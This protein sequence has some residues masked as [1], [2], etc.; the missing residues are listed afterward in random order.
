[1][2]TRNLI[3]IL[4]A[5]VFALACHSITTKQRYS[6]LFAEA[7]TKIGQYSLRPAT[8][9]QLF[10]SAMQGMLSGLDENSAYLSGDEYVDMEQ[11][12]RQQFGGIGMY[13]DINPQTKELTVTSPIPNSPAFRAGIRSG[14][15]VAAIN[16]E[17]TEGLE[18]SEAI[19]R[20]RGP[21]GE[22]VTL[23]IVE[24][25]GQPERDVTLVRE[26]I[27]I[28][29]VVGDARNADGSWS[30]LL[31]E[32][33]RIAY[34]NIVEF[35]ER[36]DQEMMDILVALEPEMRALI[37]D[38]RTNGGGLLSQAV[39]ISDLFLG[40][41]E[42][43]VEIRGRGNRLVED[44]IFADSTLQIS[45]SIPV[46]ILVDR[47]SASASEIVAACLQDQGRAVIIGER[48]YGKGTVQ[49]LIPLE[50]N[51]SSIKIT[52]A[53]YWRPSGQNIDRHDLAPDEPWGVQPDPG[54]E[55]PLTEDE[56]FQVVM[57][58][59]RR[60]YKVL[61]IF[62][63]GPDTPTQDLKPREESEGNSLPQTLSEDPVL[64]R[65]VEHLS[66]VLDQ[67]AAT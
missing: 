47:F 34:V 7:L 62:D 55:I 66:R 10:E 24:E 1:M 9:R 16:G 3:V 67:D 54:F 12:L 59:N 41:R 49:D 32:D 30:Y 56:F 38:L 63:T 18:R 5:A 21:V 33:R 51:R 35:S 37:I 27:P 20:M 40:N 50:R 23:T 52:T 17:R 25:V 39:R 58:R 8:D 44:P 11:R 6:N 60:Q 14:N 28:E 57:L 53:T 31:P 26:M 4:A 13:V 46:A 2:S 42:K 43:I 45:P 65:A 48:S 61:D 29:S 22:S 36:T 15:I 64:K 19:R